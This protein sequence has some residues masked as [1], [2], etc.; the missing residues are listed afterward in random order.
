MEISPDLPTLH[1]VQTACVTTNLR[2]Q[3]FQFG[4]IT[5]VEDISF[6]GFSLS[7]TGWLP[8]GEVVR[9]REGVLLRNIVLLNLLI[10][11]IN[12]LSQAG[13][14]SIPHPVGYKIGQ[15]FHYDQFPTKTSPTVP[16]QMLG[17]WCE[18]ELNINLC[19]AYGREGGGQYDLIVKY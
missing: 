1:I 13:P 11:C 3:M 17:W 7:Y 18:L 10:I 14:A 19:G 15:R 9:E 2:R 8:C 12:C 16:E 5:Y 6:K 4:Q